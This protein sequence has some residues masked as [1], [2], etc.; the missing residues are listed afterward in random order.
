MS[1]WIWV[2]VGFLLLAIEFAS[3]T[4]H[5]AFFA[6]GAWVVAILV[7]IGRGGSLSTQL[8]LFA[9]VS[10]FALI[11]LRPL[12]VRRLRIGETV[13]VDSLVGEQALAV[14]DI[15]PSGRGRAEM[16]GATWNAQNVGS[17]TLQRGQRC[18]VERIEGLLL[19]VKG[20]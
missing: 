18:T 12:L 11:V 13:E 2:L 19:Y 16:R 1:W 14:D 7:G 15:E 4:L 10:V 6:I 3:T 9:G 17:T 8:L 20:A 5:V